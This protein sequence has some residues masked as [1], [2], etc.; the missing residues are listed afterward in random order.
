MSG[1]VWAVDSLGGY[2]YAPE[3]S[4]VLRMEVAPKCK[5]R[6][7]C[8]AKD[9][10]QKGHNQGDRFYWNSYGRLDTRG[11]ELSEQ[12]VV[13]TGKFQVR[14]QSLVVT[15][16]GNS[17]PYTGKLD[18]LSKHPVTEI[19]KKVLKR[20]CA[21]T[22]DRAAHAQFNSTLLRVQASGGNS[23]T[24]VTFTEN[25]AVGSNLAVDFN[26]EHWKATVDGL[27]ERNIPPY[28][29]D[30][31]YL[32]SWPTTLRKVK[33]DLEAVHQ[34]TETG[35]AQIKNGEIGRYENARA[36]EQTNIAKGGPNDDADWSSDPE[37]GGDAYAASDW[38]FFFGEDTVAEAI[39]IP[40]EIRGKIPTDFGRSKG[41]MWYYLGGFGLVHG[42]NAD[43]VHD[44]RVAKWD[45]A[46]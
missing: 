6:Q 38:I 37:V 4:N 25:G 17:N 31:Y 14:Q 9:G 30:D 18:N 46:S 32:I 40:E 24:E 27:Q 19:I 36:V 22:L 45:S 13:P 2:M 23:A 5:F 39:V 3:L 42:A 43:T 33:N 1:Q 44:A 15:E 11:G 21:E 10:T 26:N 29:N 35:F 41:I 7:F 16:Y 34:Y 12:D 20:D 28:V 8:D